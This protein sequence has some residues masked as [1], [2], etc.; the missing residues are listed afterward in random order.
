MRLENEVL[1]IDTPLEDENV[2]EFYEAA[3]QDEIKTIRIENSNIS[4]AALQVMWNLKDKE[5][6]VEDEF[7]SKFFDNVKCGE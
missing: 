6:E 2:E 3:K 5:I 1:I 4:S 7:L